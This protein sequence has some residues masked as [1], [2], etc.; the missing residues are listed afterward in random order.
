MCCLVSPAPGDG[1]GNGGLFCYE[2]CQ[3]R[4]NYH[5]LTGD[6][7]RSTSILNREQG[8]SHNG[9]NQ[10]PT[11][12]LYFVQFSNGGNHRLKLSIEYFPSEI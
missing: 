8:C 2:I 6:Q 12:T 1:V 3:Q 11:Q 7:N 5:H 10:Y 9:I 4:P